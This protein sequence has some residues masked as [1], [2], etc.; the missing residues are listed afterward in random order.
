[1]KRV[2]AQPEEEHV[3]LEPEHLPEEQT[4]DVKQ[5]IKEK[6]EERNSI[7]PDEYM[8][9]LKGLMFLGALEKEVEYGGHKFLM[10][11]LREGEIMRIGQLMKDWRG[12]LTEMEARKCYTVAAAMVSVDGLPLNSAYKPEYDQI[13]ENAREVKQW[14]PAVIK[15]LYDRYIELEVSAISVSDALKK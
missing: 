9:P 10:R 5:E 12:T 13:Y 14:Y 15:Y 3:F 2:S 7:F 1:M 4:E 11:T 6:V 8:Q